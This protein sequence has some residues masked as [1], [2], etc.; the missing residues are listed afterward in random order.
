VNIPISH[1]KKMD[2]LVG[3]NALYQSRS[4]LVRVALREFLMKKLE[5]LMKSK[6]M[7]EN[8]ISKINQIDDSMYI[9]IPYEKD[10]GINSAIEYKT[11]RIIRK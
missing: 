3:E 8:S 1:I 9:Q 5:S 2:S 4:E 11:Y 10:L 7:E 6:S